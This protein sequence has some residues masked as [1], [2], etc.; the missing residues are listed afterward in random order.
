MLTFSGGLGLLGIQ[1][2]LIVVMS[3][4]GNAPGRFSASLF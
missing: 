2:T 3:M 1:L 4:T